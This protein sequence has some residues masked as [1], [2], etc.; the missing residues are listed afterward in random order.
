[1]KLT[2]ENHEIVEIKNSTQAKGFKHFEV[3]DVLN[4]NLNLKYTSGSSGGG[5][6]ASYVTCKNLTKDIEVTKSQSELVNLLNRCF[7]LKIFKHN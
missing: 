2:S 5:V 6:Y 3:G 4:F 1:M 7:E